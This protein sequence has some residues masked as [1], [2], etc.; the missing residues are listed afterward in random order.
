M[1]RGMKPWTRYALLPGAL[2]GTVGALGAFL[3]I[4]ERARPIDPA[5]Q[6]ELAAAPRELLLRD[7]QL[8]QRAL[9]RPA[10]MPEE[11]APEFQELEAAARRWAAALD[12]AGPL[13]GSGLEP[14]L[15]DLRRA[16]LDQRE[17]LGELCLRE[18]AL[19]EEADA[20]RDEIDA[21]WVALPAA[22]RAPLEPALRALAQ[23][24]RLDEEGALQGA[25]ARLW[26]AREGLRRG[27]EAPRA[28]SDLERRGR[29]LVELAAQ[30]RRERALLERRLLPLATRRLVQLEE[31]RQDARRADAQGWRKLLFAL[32]GVLGLGLLLLGMR[33]A[34]LYGALGRLLG[35]RARALDEAQAALGA[36]EA[37]QE[38]LRAEHARRVEAQAAEA[39]QERGALTERLARLEAALRVASED[40][41]ALAVFLEASAPQVEALCAGGSLDA[42]AQRQQLCALG[43]EAAFFAL[44]PLSALCQRLARAL[45]TEDRL[46]VR[47]ER[48]ALRESWRQLSGTSAGLL[49]AHKRAVE[50]PRAELEALRARL[51]Q[52]ATWPDARAALHRW[53]LAPL[54]GPLEQLAARARER[55]RGRGH[56]LRVVVDAPELH[57]DLARWGPIWGALVHAVNNA[58]DHGIERPE[59]RLGAAKAPEGR[60]ILAASV[61]QGRLLVRV[62]DD[63]RGVD[64]RRVAEL[65]HIANLPHG[66]RDAL[67]EALFHDGLS[68]GGRDGEAALGLGLGAAREACRALEGT[69]S[70]HSAAGA[71]T[72]VIF[73]FPVEV[74]LPAL[75]SPPSPPTPTQERKAGT[76]EMA[77]FLKHLDQD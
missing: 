8:R 77:A 71:G 45:Y 63:G 48:E 40:K 17:L 33:L 58:L 47:G 70:L 44:T 53:G 55:S 69:V 12:R 9:R 26:E 57:I 73:S 54:R 49:E 62:S 21:A 42:I 2:V 75:A 66:D 72:D 38:G 30:A 76:Q 25:L 32:G 11:L 7:L 10:P 41:R 43:A 46:L 74:A 51:N 65:A 16:L 28:L 24:A 15:D 60:L 29:A 27:G 59:L 6:V 4:E 52:P 61:V 13:E 64:W 23:G 34:K 39:A 19:Q 35:Q 37:A 67:A 50:V 5:L 3:L 36:A 68:T 20:L 22:E 56:G 1:G 18:R 31:A 14:A